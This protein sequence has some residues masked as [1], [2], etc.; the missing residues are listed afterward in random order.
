MLEQRFARLLEA[1]GALASERHE[2]C[3]A[4]R[5]AVGQRRVLQPVHDER[6]KVSGCALDVARRKV[7]LRLGLRRAL[8]GQPD[9]SE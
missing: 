4:H 2:H 5:V 3:D 1:Y 6:I 9:V 7:R 8:L